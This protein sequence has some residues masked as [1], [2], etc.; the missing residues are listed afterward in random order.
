L[1]AEKIQNLQELEVQE[2]FILKGKHVQFFEFFLIV[3]LCCG[4]RYC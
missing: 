1:L 2:T 4:P 3:D